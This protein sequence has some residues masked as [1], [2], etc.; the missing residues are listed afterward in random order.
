MKQMGVG[1]AAWWKQNQ[2]AILL[3]LLGILIVGGVVA[4][5]T[6]G[7]GLLPLAQVLMEVMTY[8][9]MAQAI[10]MAK[11]HIKKFFELSWSGNPAEGG[12]ELAKAFAIII[13]EF[14]ME[15]IL[16]KV[17][18]VMK[19]VKES[20]K[21]TKGFARVASV[22]KKV[23]K[24]AGNI[25]GIKQLRNVGTKSGKYAIGGINKGLAKASKS[26]GE[27]REKVLK[28]FGFKRVWMERH[29]NEIQM[30]GEFNSKVLIMEM[31]VDP[32]TG[33]KTKKFSVAEGADADDILAK[34][35]KAL[36]EKPKAGEKF[37]ID[38]NKQGLTIA[39]D[40][41]SNKLAEIIEANPDSDISDLLMRNDVDAEK[42]FENLDPDLTTDEIKDVLGKVSEH[43]KIDENIL[44][45][46][47]GVY[48]QTKSTKKSKRVVTN[49]AGRQIKK[50]EG[51]TA[52][53]GKLEVN[54]PELNNTIYKGGSSKAQ[55]PYLDSS[56]QKIPKNQQL[57]PV[58][59]QRYQS[60]SE[61]PA[62]K[63][64]AE[65][66]ILGEIGNGIETKFPHL[67]G[68][69]DITTPKPEVEGSVKMIVDQD[70]CSACKQGLKNKDTDLGVIGQF[71][72]EYP[73]MTLVVTNF[74]TKEILVIKNGTRIM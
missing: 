60:P 38:K 51:G 55:V 27:F 58:H 23:T 72:K 35:K 11:G 65:Q 47:I 43:K 34:Q 8:Y 13:N 45:Q 50:T 68:K 74:E 54:E 44:R 28:A 64:H 2:T 56:G 4:F 9:F 39:D 63:N 29:G 12:K 5:F 32:V 18:S 1:L 57:K 53:A 30:W 69:G 41:N 52:G 19:R 20:I 26:L 24:A 66:N 22:T 49:K 40:A 59:N 6:G 37:D 42:I 21:A 36:G 61:F 10:F 46:E 15:V 3:S 31:E 14:L 71:S 33:A 17:G 70:V 16:K 73:N 7:A 62:S 25:P 67:K 48:R